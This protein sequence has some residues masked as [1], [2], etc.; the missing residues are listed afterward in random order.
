MPV[1][2][3]A[4]LMTFAGV[5][6]FGPLAEFPVKLVIH[7]IE[8]ALG[9]IGAMV[10]RPAPDAWVE[11]GDEGRLV[12]PAMGADEGFH[13]FQVTLLRCA[14]G[15]DEDFVA[16]FAVVFANCKLPDGE[17]EKVKTGATFVFVE[18]VGEVGFGVFQ[19]QPHFGQPFFDQG[20][21][22]LERGEV[23]TEDDE[24]VCETDDSQSV[25]LGQGCRDGSFEAMQSNIGEE[26]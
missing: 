13:L 8:G 17:T 10:V 1:A 2:L 24:V 7:S 6:P 21:G 23:F 18:R 3:L 4:P 15:L 5:L 12:A 16:P 19:G 26:G 9:R 11:C 22:G 25:S 14:A 20:A